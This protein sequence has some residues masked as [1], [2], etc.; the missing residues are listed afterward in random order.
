MERSHY[1]YASNEEVRYSR[2]F[3]A[4][5]LNHCDTNMKT[6]VPISASSA[7]LLAFVKRLSSRVSH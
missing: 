1:M 4:M 6:T 5:D 3:L 2:L 7:S